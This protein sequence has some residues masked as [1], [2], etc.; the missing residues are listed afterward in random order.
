MT[1]SGA[2]Y[3]EH[4][5]EILRLLGNEAERAAEDNPLAR[6]MAIQPEGDQT[7]VTTTTN[8]LVQRL[9]HAI[10]KAYGGEITYDFSH[11]NHLTRVY[12]KRD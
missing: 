5:D 4:S 10:D 12:W 1:L 2:F 8:H 7:Q 9:G 6:I 3:R 11:E